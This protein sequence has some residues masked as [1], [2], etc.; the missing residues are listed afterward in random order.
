MA[1]PPITYISVN[2]GPQ[3]GTDD[4]VVGVRVVPAGREGRTV[5]GRTLNYGEPDSGDAIRVEPGETLIFPQGSVKITVK[6]VDRY[7]EPEHDGYAPVAN[8]VWSWLAIP[9]YTSDAMI[10]N[11]LLAAARR[12]DMAHVHSMG[13]LSGL[14]DSSNQPSF[15][16]ARAV[17]FNALGHAETMC[18]ALCRA[19]RMIQ[20]ADAKVSVKIPVPRAVSI[21]QNKVQ[22]IRDAFEHIDERAEGRARREGLNDAMSVFDQ[23]DFFTSGVLRYAGHSLDIKDEAVAAMVAG[24]QFIVEAAAAAGSTK[25]INVEIKQ[26]FTDNSDESQVVSPHEAI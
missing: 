14:A 25:T 6:D 10:H 22:S 8:T 24:R 1:I 16:K 2:L 13:A 15:L 9:P 3:V 23:S 19:I 4:T 11:Y 17:M 5:Y 7:S 20:Q 21:I 18:I 12:L 26:T